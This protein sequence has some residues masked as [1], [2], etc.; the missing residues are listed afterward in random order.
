M[1]KAIATASRLLPCDVAVSEK[2]SVL[3]FFNTL[4]YYRAGRTKTVYVRNIFCEA[5]FLDELIRC[6]AQSKVIATE[7]TLLTAV[8]TECHL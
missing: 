8:N 6:A 5:V 2:M 4:T 1:K 3:S 7:S